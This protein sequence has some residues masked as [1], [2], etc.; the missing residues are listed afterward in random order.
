MKKRSWETNNRCEIWSNLYRKGG[1]K[2]HYWNFKLLFFWKLILARME[3]FRAM[4]TLDFDFQLI[5]FSPGNTISA[6]FFISFYRQSTKKWSVKNE[7][8][9]EFACSFFRHGKTF[10]HFQMSLNK[11]AL[12]NSSLCIAI[13]SNVLLYISGDSI[14]VFSSLN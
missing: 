3:D 10:P 12:I 13:Y 11:K 4:Q 9:F 14:F 8:G 5:N 7:A 6:Y 1:Q 2:V